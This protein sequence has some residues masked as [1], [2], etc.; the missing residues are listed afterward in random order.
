[1]RIALIVLLAALAAAPATAGEAKA[2]EPGTSVE[3]PYLIAPVI[4]DEKL[5][6]YAYVSSKIVASSP[7]TAIE[8]RLKTPF[9]QD[10][11]VRDV[12]ATPIGKASDP[13]TVDTAALVVRLLADARRITGASNVADLKLI[14]VQI[15][16]TRPG[17]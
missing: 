9:I 11:F 7:Q 15:T 8:I 12:N 16:P 10:A 3:M 6:A 4:V 14:Q 2:P 5:V 17:S 13:A 1:M